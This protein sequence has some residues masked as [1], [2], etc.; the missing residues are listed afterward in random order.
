M[1][2]VLRFHRQFRRWNVWPAVLVLVLE[3][4]CW[5]FGQ[6]GRSSL[7]RLLGGAGALAAG[8][9]L[10][11]AT[12]PQEWTARQL[13]SVQGS[14]RS[15]RCRQLTYCTYKL[16][17]TATRIPDPLL[18]IEFLN[19]TGTHESLPR[20]WPSEG[21]HRQCQWQWEWHVP[22]AVKARAGLLGFGVLMPPVC[23]EPTLQQ[24]SP[25]NAVRDH[26]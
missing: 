15:C 6:R 7:A 8:D 1:C 10:S 26:C 19:L 13:S 14:L 2:C 9:V 18:A 25:A 11:S 20:V 5:R 22:A 17:S 21:L 16:D 12:P 4:G 23:D 3:E 24:L